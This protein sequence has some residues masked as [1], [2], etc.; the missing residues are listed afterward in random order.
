MT[1]LESRNLNDGFDHLGIEKAEPFRAAR[2]FVSH[3]CHRV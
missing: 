1:D 2:N 3:G